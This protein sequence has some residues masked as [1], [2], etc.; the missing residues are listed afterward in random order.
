[1]KNCPA[2]NAAFEEDLVPVR[3]AVDAVLCKLSEAK[4]GDVLVLRADD[5][6]DGWKVS[7][8]LA[9]CRLPAGSLPKGGV[10]IIIAPADTTWTLEAL[11]RLKTQ[12]EHLMQLRT[13]ALDE[14]EK[15]LEKAAE[16]DTGC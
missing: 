14:M 11:E 1:M 5:Y 13:K 7:Q 3:V 16:G 2:C 4:P 8:Q 12:V 15:R 6:G 9:R 10:S